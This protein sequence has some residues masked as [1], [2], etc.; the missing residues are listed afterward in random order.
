MITTLNAAIRLKKISYGKRKKVNL[1]WFYI[2][3]DLIVP[4]TYGTITF[5]FLK[6]LKVKQLIIN[7]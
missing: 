2:T 7:F 1:K 4:F 6:K 5:V 3:L